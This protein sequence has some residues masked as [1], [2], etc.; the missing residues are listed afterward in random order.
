MTSSLLGR[1]NKARAAA[2]RTTGSCS[3]GGC[4]AAAA[5]C[6]TIRSKCRFFMRRPC[7]ALLSWTSSP[8]P[9]KWPF[10]SGAS[11][12]R[13][14]SGSPP[15]TPRRR[16]PAPTTRSP[17]SSCPRASP[18]P[19]PT[20][21]GRRSWLKHTVSTARGARSSRPRRCTCRA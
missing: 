2:R 18:A 3:S 14:P 8:Y 17:S 7:I 11:K 1:C 10:N 20:T 4:S 16:T 19:G 5:T 12:L 6:L 13:S 9:R 21:S 15:R